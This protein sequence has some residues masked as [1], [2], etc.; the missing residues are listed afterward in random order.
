MTWMGA[1]DAASAVDAGQLLMLP[2]TYLTCLE[3]GLHASPREVLAAAASR[4]P[5]EM[6]M[7]EVEGSGD[8]A[9]SLSIPESLRALVEERLS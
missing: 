3:V 5:V 1:L 4:G 7:P 2:P 8:A 6:F 9:A